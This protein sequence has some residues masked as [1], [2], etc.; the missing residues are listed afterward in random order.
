LAGKSFHKHIICQKKE[1]SEVFAKRNTGSSEIF[2]Y[3][4]VVMQ[5]INQYSLL[6]G[7]LIF[8]SLAAFLLLRRGF[9]LRALI[10]LVVIGFL[11]VAGW[12]LMRPTQSAETSSTEIA[13][14]IG[15]G[16]P[17]LLELQSPY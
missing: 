15:A 9:N 14:Q 1:T 7:G 11:M 17:V 3:N 10:S 12:V 6:L 2:R 8:F 13:A 16:T 5:I 4:L